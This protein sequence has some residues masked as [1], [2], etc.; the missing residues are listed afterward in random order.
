MRIRKR[1]LAIFGC[2]FL[3]LFSGCSTLHLPNAA[4]EDSQALALRKV[5]F[6]S[7]IGNIQALEFSDFEKTANKDSINDSN[8][9]SLPL[10]FATGLSHRFELSVNSYSLVP[11]PSMI[12]LKY[13]FLGASD[14]QEPLNAAVVLR[15][16]YSFFSNSTARTGSIGG[17]CTSAQSCGSPDANGLWVGGDLNAYILSLPVGFLVSERFRF[18]VVPQLSYF[19][20]KYTR[21]EEISSTESRETD[22]GLSGLQK[23]LAFNIGYALGRSWELQG[24]AQLHD[25]SWNGIKSSRHFSAYFGASYVIGG[26]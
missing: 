16:G 14:P 7:A 19:D 4:F 20:G 17:S 13:Q 9:A 25:Y 15:Y 18:I 5:Q 23:S 11:L 22:Y 12:G 10:R 3:A 21:H 24:S 1:N 8:V 26:R 6:G 2:L